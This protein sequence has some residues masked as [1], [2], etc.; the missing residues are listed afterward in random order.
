MGYVMNRSGYNGF[1]P[2]SRDEGT[3]NQKG[4]NDF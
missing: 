3:W 2:F 4:K 1:S